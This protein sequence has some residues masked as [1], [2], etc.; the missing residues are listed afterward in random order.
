MLMI[1]LLVG[2]SIVVF[3]MVRILPGDVAT[4]MVAGGQDS[5]A[6]SRNEETI[7]AIRRSLNLDQPL[8]VQ[9]GLWLGQVARGAL[10]AHLR[11]RRAAAGHRVGSAPGHRARLLGTAVQHRR[12]LAAGFLDRHHARALPAALVWLDPDHPLHAAVGRP[13]GQPPA[14]GLPRSG[15]RGPQ[16]GAN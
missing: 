8:Y 16:F 2:V 4:L 7:Q 15:A 3:A 10:G 1:P 5:G 9:Y 13:V 14:D 11:A 6:S 12:A